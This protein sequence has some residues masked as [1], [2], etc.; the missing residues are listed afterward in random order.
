M[1][2]I[3]VSAAT[4]ARFAVAGS[5][6]TPMAGGQSAPKAARTILMVTL[7][8]ASG[9]ID[10]IAP[11]LLSQEGSL[12]LTPPFLFHY[13]ARRKELEASTNDSFNVVASGKVRTNVDRRFALE[14]DVDAH[15]GW[16]ARA[17]SGTTVLIVQ[18]S[19]PR[20]FP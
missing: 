16:E 10:P 2:G 19:V 6:M 11:V 4:I 14:D 13:I 8:Q 17:T 1:S 15:K 5:L 3:W 12:L 20:S 18:P 9:A 7:G